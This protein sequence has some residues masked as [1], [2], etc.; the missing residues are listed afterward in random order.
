MTK[1]IDTLYEGAKIYSF[2]KRTSSITGVQKLIREKIE[3]ICAPLKNMEGIN[4]RNENTFLTLGNIE[5]EFEAK[6]QLPNSS[7]D[8]LIIYKKRNNGIKTYNVKIGETKSI[9]MLG[10]SGYEINET[11]IDILV[12]QILSDAFE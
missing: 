10:S 12:E 3:I 11:T 2:K 6:F 7:E 9:T 5:I 1:W 8:E 4:Y